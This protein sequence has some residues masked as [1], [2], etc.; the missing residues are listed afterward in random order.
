MFRRRLVS[1][2]LLVPFLL[3]SFGSVGQAR[4]PEPEVRY[5]VD[6][7]DPRAEG[8]LREL[9]G[10]VDRKAG[11]LD[12]ATVTISKSNAAALQRDR[13]FG[14]VEPDQRVGLPGKNGG[15]EDAW[16]AQ[17]TWGDMVGQQLTW[18]DVAAQ[19]LT[20]GDVAAEQL[21]WGD[22]LTWGN[23]LTWGEVGPDQLTWGDI[24]AEQLT[25]GDIDRTTALWTDGRGVAY[26]WGMRAVGAPAQRQNV[27]AGV[28]VAVLD[29]G[30][31][32]EHPDLKVTGGY[33][34]I[35]R[36]ASYDDDNGH[37]THMAGIIAANGAHGLTGVAPAVELYAVKVLTAD[38]T[39]HMSDVVEG[40]NWAVSRRVQVINL[41][42]SGQTPSKVL[43]RA[44]RKARAA[45]VLVVTSAGNNGTLEGQ[46]DV[47]GV[48]ASYSS[49][50]TVGAIAPNL[51]RAY[52]SATGKEL[53]FVA[54]GVNIISTFPGGYRVGTG[55]SQ[56]T[57][58]ASGVAAA[59]I[60]SNRRLSP[61]DVVEVLHNAAQPLAP[62]GGEWRYGDGLIRFP[63]TR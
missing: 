20:W 34:A 54:P 14:L 62:E 56:A 33:N 63:G 29:S 28:K 60:A 9:G 24:G 7:S 44:L 37:G 23:Q 46:G 42:L 1:S 30:I 13:R 39:G 43:E 18:G 8:A 32:T 31:D 36:G 5:I 35:E 53:D 49:V 40:I 3:S 51:G 22:Q 61:E 58:F 16:G 25:W 52:F 6:L 59:V 26:D 38:G 50:V 11:E 4:S 15:A 21:T 12:L 19:Q 45:G 41:S 57:A 10:R 47:L 17:L 27:G 48:P 55:T 2:L